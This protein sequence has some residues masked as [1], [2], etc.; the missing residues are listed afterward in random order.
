MLHFTERNQKFI[1]NRLWFHRGVGNWSHFVSSLLS[2]DKCQDEDWF[3]WSHCLIESRW[4]PLE[5]LAASLLLWEKLVQG[6]SQPTVRNKTRIT[7]GKYHSSPNNVD[8]W[9]L[10]SNQHS[11]LD[12]T[13]TPVNSDI[14]QACVTG[15][16]SLERRDT[17]DPVIQWRNTS[18]LFNVV[19]PH[20][21][22]PKSSG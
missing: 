16:L 19:S 9:V 10:A 4:N 5:L 3:C 17:N 6:P 2:Q 15:I 8:L 7:R 18:L 12:L 20:T 22:K 21:R 13:D 14:I 11:P 1:F